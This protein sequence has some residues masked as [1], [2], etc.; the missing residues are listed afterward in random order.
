MDRAILLAGLTE[1]F[2]L[3]IMGIEAAD[4][5]I[6]SDKIVSKLLDADSNNSKSGEAFIANKK[7]ITKRN[8][9]NKDIGHKRKG[10]IIVD[11]Q[12]NHL[13]YQIIYLKASWI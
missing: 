4:N 2:K 7:Q 11:R 3:F 6:T 10:V 8:K 12:I 5:V 1:S 9:I 13:K